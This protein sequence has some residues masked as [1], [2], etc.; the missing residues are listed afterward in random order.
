MGNEMQLLE[1]NYPQHRFFFFFVKELDITNQLVIND[2]VNRNHIDG[3]ENSPAHTVV[4]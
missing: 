3:N 2:F 1:K 4:V